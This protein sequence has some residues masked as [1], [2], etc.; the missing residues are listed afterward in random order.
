MAS[1]TGW[2]GVEQLSLIL[3]IVLASIGLYTT[4]LYKSLYNVIA[5]G[6]IESTARNLPRCLQWFEP[7]RAYRFR[8][9][10]PKPIQPVIRLTNGMDRDAQRQSLGCFTR[11]LTELI[12]SLRLCQR[13]VPTSH[14]GDNLDRSI[15]RI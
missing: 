12:A 14:R 4:I 13:G 1:P 8:R 2:E 6:R 3:P 9:A 11:T 15:F 5:L 10:V 7:T